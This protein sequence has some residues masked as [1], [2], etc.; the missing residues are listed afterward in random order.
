VFT[1]QH[2]LASAQEF[3]HDLK[4]RMAKYGRDLDDLKIMPGLNPIV[5]RTTREAEENIASCSR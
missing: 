4:G 5:G 3:Y 1:P 2:T